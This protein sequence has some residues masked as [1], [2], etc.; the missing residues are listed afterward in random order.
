MLMSTLPTNLT[1]HSDHTLPTDH[2]L[3]TDPPDHPDHTTLPILSMTTNTHTTHLVGGTTTV[4]PTPQD[5]TEDHMTVTLPTTSDQE[6]ADKFNRNSKTIDPIY[7]SLFQLT[8]VF[9]EL[10]HVVQRILSRNTYL[11]QF[12]VFPFDPYLPHL[13]V[14]Y[15]LIR[16]A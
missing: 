16:K 3:P 7:A 1:D 9:L 13:Q 11:G 4:D 8:V 10:R 6:S 15:A 2:I 14:I 5:S 12:V